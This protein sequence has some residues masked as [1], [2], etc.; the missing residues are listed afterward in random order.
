MPSI[1]K[2]LFPT[3][4]E[5]LS[6]RCVERL[7]PLKAAGLEEIVFLFVIDREEVAFNLF[8]GF[9]K[10]LA[11]QLSE[12]AR[13]R[14][15][16]WEK[17]LEAQGIRGRHIVEIGRPEGKILEVSCREEVGLIV[18]G[19]QK[20]VPADAVYLGGTTMGVLRRTAIPVLVCKHGG[21]EAAVLEA[22]T[23]NEFERVLYAT[24]FS[25]DSRCA[26]AFLEGLGGAVRRVDAVHVITERDFKK[27]TE[28]EIREEEE[29]SQG[30]LEVVCERLRGKGVEAQAHLLAGHT[31]QEILQAAADNHSTC[32]LMGTK[33]RHGLKEV[34][35]GSASH[36]VAELSPVP[37]I[38]VPRERAECYI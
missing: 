38:L 25:E 24:D 2:I 26:Q 10:K 5:D 30:E 34:W 4:F 18:A 35:L 20:H 9:D 17:K 14:F 19:R 29:K 37:V 6:Y 16:D 21:P 12:E 7:F 11:H 31:A 22:T 36:R 32:I 23:G 28:E 13:L 8:R 27:H 1:R 15:E 33:G 3:K